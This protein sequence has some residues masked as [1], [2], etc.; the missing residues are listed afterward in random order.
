MV[1]D[2]MLLSSISSMSSLFA[3]SNWSNNYKDVYINGIHKCHITCLVVIS[4]ATQLI[5]TTISCDEENDIDF[6][7]QF[8]IELRSQDKSNVD[9]DATC[10][11][12]L[13]KS[14]ANQNLW[15]PSH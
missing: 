7:S 8:A 13:L 5:T 3:N 10:E 14:V 15:F 6:M 1:M 11:S 4:N 12:L 9:L 2:R